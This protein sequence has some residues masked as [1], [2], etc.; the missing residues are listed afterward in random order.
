MKPAQIFDAR[1]LPGL[2]SSCS[3]QRPIFES[4]KPY[5]GRHVRCSLWRPARV[6]C[7]RFRIFG[8]EQVVPFP[9]G[10]QTRMR[11]RYTSVPKRSAKI[12]Q[13]GA[14]S[15]GIVIRRRVRV[16][17]FQFSSTPI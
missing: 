5:H 6:S 9:A 4:L 15:R 11:S 16:G 14:E 2:S 7:S 13:G 12:A 17:V 1:Y 8:D 10:R 3:P